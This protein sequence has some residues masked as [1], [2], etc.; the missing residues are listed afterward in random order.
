MEVLRGSDGPRGS[1]GST[2]SGRK[3]TF[4]HRKRRKPSIT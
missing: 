1:G 3:N 2:G 4:F